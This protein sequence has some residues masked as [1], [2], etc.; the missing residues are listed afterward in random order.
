MKALQ[1]VYILKEKKE[2]IIQVARM[3]ILP[4]ERFPVVFQSLANGGPKNSG[5]MTGFKSKLSESK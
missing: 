3:N 5:R 2:S 1:F 4:F